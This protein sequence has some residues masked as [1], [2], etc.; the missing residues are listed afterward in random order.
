[1]KRIAELKEIFSTP[2]AKE[3][4]K[5]TSP[6][7]PLYDSDDIDDEEWYWE[8]VGY[9]LNVRGAEIPRTTDESLRSNEKSYQAMKYAVDNSG[10]SRGLYTTEEMAT[11]SEYRDVVRVVINSN[12]PK[13]SKIVDLL[14]LANIGFQTSH[15]DEEQCE[16]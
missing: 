14:L 11:C 13:R 4:M 15:Q 12:D 6:S 7:E 1:M 16:L 2:E 8:E 3:A 9:D 10:M 5:P